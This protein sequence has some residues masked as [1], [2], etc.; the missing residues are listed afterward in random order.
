MD[1]HSRTRTCFYAKHLSMIV[2]FTS[3]FTPGGAEETLSPSVKFPL[4][5]RSAQA[6]VAVLIDAFSQRFRQVYA[7]RSPM[8]T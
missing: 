6:E 4:P 8:T 5:A 2:A 7:V 1:E 3:L